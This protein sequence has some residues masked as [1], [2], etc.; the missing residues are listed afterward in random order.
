MCSVLSVLVQCSMSRSPS[1]HSDACAGRDTNPFNHTLSHPYH[2]K[3]I[4][5]LTLK[6]HKISFLAFKRSIVEI[7]AQ[8]ISVV[9]SIQTKGLK[10]YGSTDPYL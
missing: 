6:G 9:F 4:C 7:T 8:S 2:R 3:K 10:S 5:K 1:R